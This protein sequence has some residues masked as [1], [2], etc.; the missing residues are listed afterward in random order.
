MRRPLLLLVP[1]LFLVPLTTADIK[2]DA[3]TLCSDEETCCLLGDTHWGCCP[4]PQAVCCADKTHCCPTGTTCDP[5]GARC[6]GEDPEFH[7]PMKKKNPARKAEKEERNEFN[8]IICPDKASKCPDGSTCCLLEQGT[9]GCCPVPS[10]VCCSDM[11]HCCPNGFTCH[12]KFCSQ[13]YILTPHLKK[14]ASTNIHRKPAVGFLSDEKNSEESSEDVVDDEDVNPIA[15]GVGKTCPAKTTCCAIET[16]NG[17]DTTMCCPLSN[18]VCCQDT[19]CPAGYHCV[20]GG[21][22]EKHARAK[23][24]VWTSHNRKF[25]EIVDD[26]DD[27]E[28]N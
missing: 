17:E 7:I 14:F 9:Y 3:E 22:C 8:E 18:A 11:L 21:K 1:A 4:M 16:E 27:D 12:G 23:K 20:A 13:N 24:P 10:A 19:C 28:E 25:Y 15:C 6:V 2:C 5:Q 26:V